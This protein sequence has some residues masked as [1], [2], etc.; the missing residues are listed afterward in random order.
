MDGTQY[1]G[2]KLF[3]AT[4]PTPPELRSFLEAARLPPVVRARRRRND[5]WIKCISLS[6]NGQHQSHRVRPVIAIV[7]ASSPP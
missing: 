5:G 3:I 7:P 6:S 4:R 2:E 1:R